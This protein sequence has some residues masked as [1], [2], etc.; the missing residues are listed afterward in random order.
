MI[1]NYLYEDLLSDVLTYGEA[2]DDRT[3]TGT[4]SLFAPQSLQFDLSNFR[5][6]LIQSK[7]VAVGMA[8]AE[9]LWMLQGSSRIEDLRAMSPRMADIWSS[10]ANDEGSVGP[11]YGRQ[12]RSAGGSLTNGGWGANSHYGVDQL[13]K[14]VVDLAQAPHTR[15]AV[16]SLWS[17]PELFDMG[18]EPCMVLFQFSLRGENY[19]RLHLHVYQRSA[20]MMLG[21]PFDLYQAGLIAHLVARELWLTTGR[22]ITA[23]R[24]VWSAGDV[25]VYQNQVEAAEAQIA[26]WFEAGLPGTA[27]NVGIS[28]SPAV[29]L[30]DNTLHPEHI[31]VFNY[32]PLKPIDAGTPAV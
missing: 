30:L 2:R 20:D 23:T 32:N 6:P 22:H 31:E 24:L 15:R 25:H 16:V 10:W 11:T 4:L 1:E 18:I 12:W 5:V 17:V 3:G 8:T 19:D 29:R 13:R 7:R 26:Q 9:I 27:G 28:P 21:V 14:L